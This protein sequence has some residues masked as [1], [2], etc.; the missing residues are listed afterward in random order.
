MEVWQGLLARL[1]RTYHDADQDR[2]TLER[3][4]D[5]SSR[6]LQGLYLDLKRNSESEIAKHQRKLEESNAVL[7]ATLESANAGIAVVD[8]QRRLI[9]VNRRFGE[10]F[11]IPAEVMTG[12]DH[13]LCVEHASKR[14]SDPAAAVAR[15]RALHDSAEVDEQ[16][17]VLID[18]TIIERYS[19]P[20]KLPASLEIVGRVT[21]F[22]DVTHERTLI[23]QL[24]RA[25][26]AAEAAS[27]AKSRFLASMS[28]ELRTPLNA[29][30]GLAEL[31]HIDGA[32]PITPIQAEYVDGIVD[33]GRH[34]LA[35]VND[36]LDLAKVEAGKQD[37]FPEP[38]DACEAIE[39]AV[40]MLL[41]LATHRGVVLASTVSTT[42]SQ[43][44]ADPLRLRQILYNLISNAVKFTDRDRRVEVSA[45][46]D[47]RGVAIAVHDEGIGISRED[48]PRLFRAFEQLGPVN[49]EQP[50]GT[51]LGLALTKRL[52]DLHG[53]TIEVESQPGIGTTFTVRMP[54]SPGSSHD[55]THPHR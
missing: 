51:G 38:V 5:I 36:V 11:Q 18:G 3:S 16:E 4:I 32:D 40:S 45:V 12:A 22:R 42:K 53:G 1:S 28:H 35:L 7:R 30:I 54:S 23:H 46:T 48:Q 47:D 27:Q 26:E 25:R 41:P 52:V 9:A 50:P 33:S 37:F 24:E 34:L 44:F 10:I 19:A 20:I 31:L 55:S 13:A 2:Y 49:S 39:E 17:L 15:I 14:F 6:E 29:V 8:R 43:V 21:F